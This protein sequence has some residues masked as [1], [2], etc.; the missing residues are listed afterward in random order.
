[1]AKNELG[2][3]VTRIACNL[4]KNKKSQALHEQ[5][6]ENYS[7]LVP[8]NKITSFISE[9]QQIVE[10]S[11][12]KFPRFY[13]YICHQHGNSFTRE[14]IHI[15]I[16]PENSDVHIGITLHKIRDVWPPK[17]ENL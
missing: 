5:L 16:G 6:F 8:T 1:M 14:Y 10:K 13:P 11:N 12:E 15:T 2:Y 9:V 17:K 4:P 3:L 7:K